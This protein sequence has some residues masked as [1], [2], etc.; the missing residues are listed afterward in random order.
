M[1]YISSLFFLLSFSLICSAQNLD[2]TLLKSYSKEELTKIKNADP[3]KYDVLVYALD[4]GTYLSEYNVEKHGQ[5]NLK[6]L[7]S[8]VSLPSFTDLNLKIESYN[9]YFYAPKLDKIVVVK[10]EWVLN[11][12]KSKKK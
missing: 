9:Q 1:K 5:L 12:E 8:V 11:F 4:Y 7:P 10:S 6:E 2:E 3:E